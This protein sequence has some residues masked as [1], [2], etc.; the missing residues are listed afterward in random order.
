M[1][2]QTHRK[3]ALVVGV[4]PCLGLALCR[5]LA[6]AG[7]QVWA[8]ARS[9]TPASPLGGELRAIDPNIHPVAGDACDTAQMTALV[10]HIDAGDA[11][12]QLM[13]FNAARLHIGPFEDLS[14]KEF[15]QVWEAGVLGA[16]VSARACLPAM[17]VRGEGAALFVG[18]T[19]SLRGGANFAAFSSAKF[20]LRGLVQSL[21][22]AY[23]PRGVH[24]AHLIIDGLISEAPDGMAP[25]AI[26]ETM[27]SLV[28]QPRCAWTQELD[29][30]AHAERF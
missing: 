30:R 15:T 11:P 25:Q 27:M 17:A 26:A 21:S 20:A 16:M 4:G 9:L 22:R 12:L 14:P 10:T 7:Y 28:A 19:A 3:S 29:L 1:T 2:S 5:A 13:V 24:V 18:A 6:E 23:W 8:V